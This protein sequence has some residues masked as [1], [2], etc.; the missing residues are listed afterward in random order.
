MKRMLCMLLSLI[1]VIGLTACG[2]GG[3]TDANSPAGTQ[4]A[5][6]PLSSAEIKQM[7]TNPADFKGRT[8]E[9]IGKVFSEP[10]YDMDGVYFQMWGDPQNSE[11]NTVV[12]YLD[13]EFELVSGDYVKILGTV[14]DV[15]EG[16][17]M[18]GGKIIAPSIL[19]ESLEVMSYEDAI[20][21]ALYTA[22]PAEKTQDQIG[23]KVTV[24]K[25]ELS[26]SETRAYITIENGGSDNFSLYS[27]NAKIVQNGKQYE[28]QT[29]YEADYQDIQTD[30]M[31]GITTEG[32]I[33]FP[34][35]ENA[36]FK[37]ILEGR[38]DN[39]NE[40]IAPYVFELTPTA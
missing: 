12:G 31:V 33:C 1:L 10:E 34:K 19:A 21:P 3:T 5:Q 29:N 36:S 6:K 15:F 16:E 9:L 8:V 38:S 7:Y 18:M 40:D 27:F 23:Y 30:L 28:E 39:W 22:V 25:V 2:G 32:I 4:E 37:L 14:K 13:P 17:N 35:I 26:E 11:L 24:E 20:A